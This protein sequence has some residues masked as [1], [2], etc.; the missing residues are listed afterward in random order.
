MVRSTIHLCRL[1]P[2]YEMIRPPDR[3]QELS[4]PSDRPWFQ[5][6]YT[7]PDHFQYARPTL[8]GYGF[9]ACIRQSGCI[10]HAVQ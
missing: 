7:R 3:P 4:Q 2:W 9:Q 5:F 8:R 10:R 6:E 1:L